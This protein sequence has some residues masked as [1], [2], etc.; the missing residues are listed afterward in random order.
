MQRQMKKF[1]KSNAG[2]T[3]VE[4]IVCILIMGMVT[5][6]VTF[7]ISASRTSYYSVHNEVSM[8]T[9][10]DMAI[11]YIN[12]IALEA[13][14]YYDTA[15]YISGSGKTY[16]TLC[17]RAVDNYTEY[18]YFI[19]HEIE[20]NTL[21]F[22]KIESSNTSVIWKP[23]TTSFQLSEINIDA[24]LSAFNIYGNI[25]KLLAM[26]VSEFNPGIPT[27][28]SEAGLLKLSIKLTYGSSNYVANKNIRSRNIA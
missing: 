23:G 5:G 1:Y 22:S 11:T 20:T 6:V 4:L 12:D 3:L 24:T 26:Y 13:T 14:E 25:R 2:V 8:Q 15:Q 9:E 17:M 10:A 21:R 18:F 16:R 27:A 28:T 7:F 19:V